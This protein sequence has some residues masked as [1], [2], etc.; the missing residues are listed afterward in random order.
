LSGQAGAFYSP[1][2]SRLAPLVAAHKAAHWQHS[3]GA[4]V[5]GDLALLND[6]AAK[7]PFGK[8][9]ICGQLSHECP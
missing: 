7:G 2:D 1:M 5:C 9:R 8:V 3:L 4:K 6:K